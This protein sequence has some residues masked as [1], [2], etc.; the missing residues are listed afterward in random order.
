M[1]KRIRLPRSVAEVLDET[2]EAD[3]LWFEQHPGERFRIRRAS[4]AELRSNATVALF[5]SD[6]EFV[7]AAETPWPHVLVVTNPSGGFRLRFFFASTAPQVLHPGSTTP[8]VAA[9]IAASS[10]RHFCS[11]WFGA[12][13]S[14][15][16]PPG[17]FDA[18]GNLKRGGGAA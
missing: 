14:A 1:S 5:D 4:D 7:A 16:D 9:L 10:D 11:I 12:P 8:Q 18:D 17:G 15:L 13:E 2:T 6:P 3:R